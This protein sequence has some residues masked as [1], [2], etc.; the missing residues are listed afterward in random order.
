[1]VHLQHSSIDRNVQ[2]KDLPSNGI[3]P[4][5]SDCKC[6]NVTQWATCGFVSWMTLICSPLHKTLHYC[7]QTIHCIYTTDTRQIQDPWLYDNVLSEIIFNIVFPMTKTEAWA[8][9]SAL[10]NLPPPL[11]FEL[12]NL[13]IGVMI[14][15]LFA[16]IYSL[17][18]YNNQNWT[19]TGN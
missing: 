2:I 11:P 6:Q 9:L 3:S 19:C 1:M 16:Y 8:F 10:P 5:V 15:H 18:I 12:V 14:L 4:S 13:N 7:K 17:S